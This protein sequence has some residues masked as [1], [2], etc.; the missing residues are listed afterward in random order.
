MTRS[1]QSRLWLLT[2]WILV[3]A[4]VGGL[5]GYFLCH[6]RIQAQ[7]EVGIASTAASAESLV[8]S[9]V[10]E[11]HAVLSALNASHLQPC[12]P[13]E[14]AML[15]QT[16]YKA[17]H[18]RDA[19]R[20]H[21]GQMLC[22]AF[23]PAGELPQ[24]PIVP[25][26]TTADGFG[27]Y[28]SVPPYT[29]DGYVT[30]LLQEG[31]FYVVE[32]PN[33]QRRLRDFPDTVE[34][35]TIEAGTGAR[36]R[37][38]GLP[39]FRNT[40]V[41]DRDWEGRDGDNLYATKCSPRTSFCTTAYASSSAALHA[42][43]QRT[44]W[45][46]AMGSLLGGLSVSCGLLLFQLRL[47]TPNQLRRAIRRGQV[48]VVYQP[49]VE[50]RTGRVVAAEAL[51]RWTDEDGNVMNPASFVRLAEQRGFIGELTS[52]VVRRALEDFRQ[53]LLSDR[54][55][56]LNVNVTAS[57]LVDARFVIA[58]E[59]LLRTF[60][61]TPDR[62]AFEVTEGSTAHKQIA[63]EAIHELRRRGHWIE[64]DDFGTGY[65]SL[66]YLKDIPVDAIKIDQSF[67]QAIETHAVMGDILPQI[68]SIAKALKL[69]V[70][71]EG[72]ETPHQAEYFANYE[73]R[74]HGQGWLFGR[75]VP[76]DQFH[77]LWLDEDAGDRSPAE[78]AG[79]R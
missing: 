72:I 43:R 16:I 52:L 49:I 18:L 13:A 35:T 73:G 79:I 14:V 39:L 12:S 62:F 22:S 46:A 57:D 50:L 76:S 64:I 8:E 45:E 67:T 28:R 54:E 27:F 61:V 31:D 55:F 24:A 41:L 60:R 17:R 6:R 70:I 25:T 47:T 10:T 7:A 34:V 26:I 58:V 20:I 37:P 48:Q 40:P 63:I 71:V 15:R 33:F 59:E 21:N 30:I 65:S 38:S 2:A 5:I 3:G 4:S 53:V 74:I 42:G 32:D 9:L 68:L 51:A 1:I 56:Q 19:G 23:F 44:A 66:A 69:L 78:E 29:I 77:R 75:P 11:S 36:M